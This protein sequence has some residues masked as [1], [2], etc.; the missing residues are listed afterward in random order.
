MNYYVY[1]LYSSTT[2]RYY[3]G[4]TNDLE[5]RLKEHNLGQEKAT[6]SGLPWTLVWY[7]FKPTKGQ[8]MV[9]EKKLKN[10]GTQKRLQDFMLR[11][12]DGGPDDQQ[13]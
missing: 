3:K 13:S 4:I 1:I 6:R 10:I 11:H 2:S 7:T 5:R 9:L 12:P 8:A